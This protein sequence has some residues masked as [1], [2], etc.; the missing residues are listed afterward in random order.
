M[1]SFSCSDNPCET[2]RSDISFVRGDSYIMSVTYGTYVPNDSP[3]PKFSFVPTNITGANVVFSY[4][5]IGDAP[6]FSTT[7]GDFVITSATGGAFTLVVPG[8]LTEALAGVELCGGYDMVL[9]LPESPI[10]AV[11]F[12]QTVLSGQLTLL[13]NVTPF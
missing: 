9:E 10:A 1:S 13:P 12:R 6:Y 2:Q 5:K 4:G 8:A 7:A 3:P 11:P